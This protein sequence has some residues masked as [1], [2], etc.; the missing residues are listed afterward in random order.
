[1]KY[2]LIC[3]MFLSCKGGSEYQKYGELC[4]RM[5]QTQWEVLEYYEKNMTLPQTVS[6]LT[7]N[8]GNPVVYT[9]INRQE[10]RLSSVTTERQT[11]EVKFFIDNKSLRVS[12]VE[13]CPKEYI[14]VFTQNLHEMTVNSAKKKR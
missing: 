9:K 7:N 8:W 4:R 1:M 13:K 5:T 10:F 12:E 14:E 6:Q 3:L 2:L 11:V